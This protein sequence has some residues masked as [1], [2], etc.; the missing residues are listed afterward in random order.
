MAQH[1]YLARTYATNHRNMS[2]NGTRC[3]V[4]E[5]FGKKGGITNGAEWYSVAG[6][7][8]DFN[9]LASNTFEITLELGCDK[10]PPAERLAEEWDNN[11]EALIKFIQQ[12]HMGIKGVVMDVQGRPVESALIRVE[13]ITNGINHI[14]NHD[15]TTSKLFRRS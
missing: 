3:D 7:M 12:S 6:G 9:Y 14:I 13:N 8:Q 11:R 1:R 10:F 15:V 4:D 2:K 5:D